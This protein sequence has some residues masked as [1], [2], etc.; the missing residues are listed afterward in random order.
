MTTKSRVSRAPASKYPLGLL[1]STIITGSLLATMMGAQLL[2]QNE[3]ATALAEP[4]VN[5]T[6]LTNNVAPSTVPPAW[7]T[8]LKPIPTV[9]SPTQLALSEPLSNTAPLTAIPTLPPLPE[10]IAPPPA[11]S[12]SAGAT[13]AS[14]VLSYELKEIKPVQMPAPVTRSRSSR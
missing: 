7:L 3:A 8:A 11:Q 2:S 5:E 12:S 9:A 6:S 13:D 4:S 14:A 1:R 10:V